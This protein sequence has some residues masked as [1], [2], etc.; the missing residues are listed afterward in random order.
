MAATLKTSKQQYSRYY[1]N[2]RGVDF[3][4]ALSDVDDNRLAFAVNMYR[5][6]NS[7]QGES[8]ETIPGFR[9]I[10]PDAIDEGEVYGIHAFV[11]KADDGMKTDILV[12]VGDS[13]FKLLFNT[14]DGNP[15]ASLLDTNMNKQK[16][17]SFSFNNRLYIIDGKNY[18]YYDGTGIHDASSVDSAYI[19]TTHI[20]IIPGGE[21]RDTGKE[22]DQRNLFSPYFKNTFVGDGHVESKS[23]GP[24]WVGTN[25]YFL[26]ERDLDENVVYSWKEDDNSDYFWTGSDII[27]FRYT[28]SGQTPFTQGDEPNAGYVAFNAE[29]NKV[30]VTVTDRIS[31]KKYGHE[32]ACT[33]SEDPSVLTPTDGKRYYFD[34]KNGRIKFGEAPSDPTLVKMSDSETLCYPAGYAGIEITAKKKI[35][36]VSGLTV[37]LQTDEPNSIIKGCTIATIFDKRVFMSG[38]PRYPNHVFYCGRNSVTGH[39]DPTYWGVLNY[40]QE[41]ITMSPVTGLVP[42][43]DTL[44]VLKSDT[45]QECSIFYRKPELTNINVMP[46]QYNGTNGAPGIGCVG[47]CKNFID[48][49]VFLSNKGLEAVGMLSTAYERS[50]YHRSY[51]IDQKLTECDLASAV[52]EVWNGWLIILVDGKMFLADSRKTFTHGT[53]SK[54]YEWFYC[55][56]IGVWE[57]QTESEKGDMTGGTFHK[58]VCLKTIGNDLYFGTDNGYLCKFNFDLRTNGEI[59]ASAY[60]FDGRTIFCCAAT[61]MDNCGVPGLT[62]NTVKKSTVIKTRAMQSSAAKVK[63]RTNR[64]PYTQI[65]RINSTLFSFDNMDFDDFSFIT[66]EQS[67]FSVREKE[68]KWVE[69]Q[70]FIYSDEFMK[71]FSLNYITY[72][73]QIAGRFKT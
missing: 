64:K 16:S 6:Y 32:L 72:R 63:I 58:A 52:M 37:D 38:N 21:N 46:V 44:M 24:V 30:W 48:D 42:V 73:Y 36:A 56:N 43:S 70:Y 28:V 61:K 33:Y 1:G 57:G 59:P 25:E 27:Q 66:D 31:V 34:P 35:S 4:S 54:Q 22:Y 60:T 19:P 10:I 11:N 3:A 20:N 23:E 9:R 5:D 69:K 47:A 26:S 65:A 18:L 50:I 53:G 41:G 49:P 15:V 51:L 13:L 2:L 67:L 7:G 39:I 45:K 17:T 14:I 40:W 29:D 71:P 12:H 62:K 55:E 68:K 8:V